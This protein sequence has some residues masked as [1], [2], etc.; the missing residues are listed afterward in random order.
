MNYDEFKARLDAIAPDRFTEDD[1]QVA[2]TLATI[3]GD[4]ITLWIPK[5]ATHQFFVE[6]DDKAVGTGST[7][8]AALEQAEW[9]IK[10]RQSLLEAALLD[11]RLMRQALSPSIRED[12]PVIR[13][14]DDQC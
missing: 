10:L 7:V 6:L 8:E 11:I 13:E 4:Q 2:H 12:H 3:A 1:D 9:R 5:I 14:D